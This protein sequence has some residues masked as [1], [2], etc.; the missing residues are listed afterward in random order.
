MSHDAL[1]S[2]TAVAR[3]HGGF[4][5]VSDGTTAR[6]FIN[7]ATPTC[8]AE[9]LHLLELVHSEDAQGVAAVRPHLGAQAG[10]MSGAAVRAHRG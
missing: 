2:G 3:V 1:S 8:D 9:L 6:R 7:S 5:R 4:T 10:K